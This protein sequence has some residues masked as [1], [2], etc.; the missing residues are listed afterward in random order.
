MPEPSA[1]NFDIG[2]M[3]PN[4][5]RRDFFVTVSAGAVGGFAL[6]QGPA[7]AAIVR[8]DI[9]RLPPYGN[10]T[11]AP[12]I[13]SRTVS[14]VNGLTVHMLEADTRRRAGRRCCCCMASRSSP[15]A[16]AR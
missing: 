8:T 16:G 11:I 1:T 3:T 2:K 13:R 7:R 15:I 14:N 9:A 12:G 10:S 5:S 4:L 6:A